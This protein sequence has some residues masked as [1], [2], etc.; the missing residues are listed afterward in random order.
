MVKNDT[1]TA[2]FYDNLEKEIINPWR[3]H[4]MNRTK[5]ELK[6]ATIKVVSKGSHVSFIF[7]SKK[8]IVN[9]INNFL[10]Q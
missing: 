8:E 7:E 5:T 4:S 6:E 9:A 2:A 3:K 10:L 1:V